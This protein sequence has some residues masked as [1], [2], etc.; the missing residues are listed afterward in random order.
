MVV[1]GSSE[2]TGQPS[3]RSRAIATGGRTMPNGLYGRLRPCDRDA[4]S[5]VTSGTL[6]L[7]VAAHRLPAHRLCRHSFN[8]KARLQ[9]CIFRALTRVHASEMSVQNNGDAEDERASL[10]PPESAYY[11][12]DY[13]QP[14]TVT[15]T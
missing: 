3:S 15:S 2:L 10:L 13:P 9:A 8:H 5:C 11:A 1:Y 14:E 7:R 12:H 6:T 4:T